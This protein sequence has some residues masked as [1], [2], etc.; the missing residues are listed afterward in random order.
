VLGHITD[1]ERV[2]AYRALRVA[3]NDKTPLAGFEQDDYVRYGPFAGCGLAEL[4][5]EFTHAR[6]ANVAM[7]RALDEEAW[8]RR[9][10]ANNHE[11]S[12]RALAYLMAGHARHHLKILEEK[13][14]PALPRP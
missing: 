2:F 4:I 6:R 13:Y 1:V 8:L 10:V 7:L 9:G 5:E 14:F 3:R 11:V 12:V